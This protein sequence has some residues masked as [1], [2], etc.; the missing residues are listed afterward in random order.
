MEHLSI[1]N[2]TLPNRL[3]NVDA[4]TF[5]SI[6]L[7]YFDDLFEVAKRR[8][9]SEEAAA[10][11]V[12]DI[13]VELWERREKL[14]IEHLDR[15]L[16]TAVKYKVINYIRDS[17]IRKE[18]WNP[19]VEDLVIYFDDRAENKLAFEELQKAVEQV[20]EQVPAKTREIFRLNRLE[21]KTV[22]E[23]SASLHIPERTVEYH[24]TQ[25]L[26]TLRLHLKEFVTYLV[27]LV[28]LSS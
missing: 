18:S 13:F 12:Q 23:I 16:F 21:N 8:L 7:T 4:E 17:L 9:Q 11:I 1:P 15:Y 25:S 20:L 19:A 10:E 28:S 3:N 5:K 6:Y 22:K 2:Y 27:L 26:R 24:I 14:N